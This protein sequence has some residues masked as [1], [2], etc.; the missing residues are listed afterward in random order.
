LKRVLPLALLLAVAAVLLWARPDA[1]LSMAELQAHHVEV[2][3]WVA[4]H[5]GLAVLAFAAIHFVAK[6]FLIPSGPFMTFAA[7]YLLGTTAATATAV[8]TGC[9]AAAVL[10]TVADRAVG[11]Q[12]RARAIPFVDR[13]GRGFRRYGFSYLVAMRLIPVMPFSV[14]TIAPAILGVPFRT[15][16]AATLVGGFPSQLIYASIGGALGTLVDEGASAAEMLQSPRVLAPLFA[17][18]ALALAPVLLNHLRDR[19]AAAAGTR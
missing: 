19:Y 2:L 17:L 16:M 15:F 4:A 12:L 11:Q 9:L 18:A 5:Y 14:A 10:F 8:L 7:G 6:T 13:I 3:D 1:S